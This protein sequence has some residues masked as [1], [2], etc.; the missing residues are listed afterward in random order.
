MADESVFVFLALVRALNE[1]DLEG[2]LELTLADVLLRPLA[3]CLRGEYRRHVGVR[4]LGGPRAR[5]RG[6]PAAS[7]LCARRTRRPNPGARDAAPAT[8]SRRRRHP[9]TQRQRRGLHGREDEA[10]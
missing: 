7:S 10:L 4:A 1:G 6:R 8:P 9:A 3:P 5:M 2:M